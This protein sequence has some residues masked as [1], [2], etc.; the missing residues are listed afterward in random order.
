MKSDEFNLFEAENIAWKIYDSAIERGLIVPGKSEKELNNQLLELSKEIA[1]TDVFWHKRIVRSGPNTLLP[2]REN[3]PD[4]I[5]LEDDILFLD[6]GPVLEKWE[7]D[8]GMTVVIGSDPDKLKLKSDTEKAWKEGQ[9]FMLENTGLTGADVYDYVCTLA[10]KYGWEYGNEH[11]G[12]LIG[13]FPHEKLQGEIK[14]NYLHPEN[15][16]IINSVDL[17]KKQRY[18]ILEIHFIDREK[19][20]GGFYEAFVGSLG[21]GAPSGN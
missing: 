21:G 12:H 13:E 17:N 9:K 7:A 14:R 15:K 11:C 18:W 5:L 20:I 4:R 10:R 2:Y 6:F 3:P 19:Q 8:I 16:E 1:K